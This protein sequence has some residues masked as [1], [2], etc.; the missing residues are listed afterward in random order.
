[1]SAL[2]VLRS[3]ES[4][5]A[6][7]PLAGGR[8]LLRFITCGSVDDGKSTLIGRLLYD[9]GHLFEDQLGALA[10]DSVQMGTQGGGLDLALALD[11][12]AAEREQGI[13][14]DVAYRYFST[15]RRSF[16]VADTPG[17]EEYTRNMATGASTADAAILLVDVRKGV[18]TQTRRH[19]V[20][21]GML[22]IR[23]LVLAVNKMDL[24]GFEPA[25]FERVLGEALALAQS[26]GVG[27]TGIPIA[28]LT[29]DN[30]TTR[31]T[32]MPWYEGPCLLEWLEEVDVQTVDAADGLRF[33]VQHVSRPDSSFRGYAGLV[34]GGPVWIGQSVTI[35]PSGRTT[36]VNRIVTYDG[37]L[38]IASPGQSVTLV[39]D[40]EA[41]VSR[42]SVIV[43]GTRPP[44][45]ERLGARLFWMSSAPLKPGDA[46]LAKIGTQFVPA[47]VSAISGRIALEPLGEEPAAELAANDIGDV[48][49]TFDRK[50][51]AERYR[52]GRELG[53]LILVERDTYATVAMGLVQNAAPAAPSPPPERRAANDNAAW[54][55]NPFATAWRSMAKTVTWRLLGTFL[56]V[57]VAYAVT[58]NLHLALL[59]G[60]IEVLAKFVLYFGHERLWARIGMGLR[61][62]A[63]DG[64]P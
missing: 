21:V 7:T 47:S 9:S 51:V 62:A 48:V 50:I 42:G 40:G 36:H 11:G 27:V 20:L 60:G 44:L 25:A 6:E 8:D 3:D 26:L 32:A 28:A 63:R 58:Q 49:I 39:L 34:T 2:P 35:L 64:Q 17:H 5:A 54:L 1:M 13:T 45:T 46:Y 18:T 29:G 31:S 22:G 33:A 10:Q 41:D 19:A 52:D 56:T 23:H 30:V 24:V 53:S 61:P 4:G 57:L 15:A 14:I 59:I 12:L 38:D 16:I 37:D 55:A 43:A